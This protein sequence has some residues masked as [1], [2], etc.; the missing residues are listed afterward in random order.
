MSFS[1]SLPMSISLSIY[2]LS[3]FLS[4]SLF[5]YLS[6][7]L[8]TSLYLSQNAPGLLSKVF[9]SSREIR[10]IIRRGCYQGTSNAGPGHFLE[11]VLFLV[12][13][14]DSIL[15]SIKM[16]G[17]MISVQFD[18]VDRT[19]MC[20][21]IFFIIVCQK[22]LLK[23]RGPIPRRIWWQATFFLSCQGPLTQ[24]QEPSF[25]T[26]TRKLL[27][28]ASYRGLVKPGLHLFFF[29]QLDII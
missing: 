20:I 15:W 2:F 9:R 27:V 26:D 10:R 28:S 19:C 14:K 6:M 3:I 23:C 21:D 22:F 29:Q 1:L 24:L 4:F 18:D 17:E 16:C 25:E 12:L 7:S 13:L 8:S 11:F 5:I